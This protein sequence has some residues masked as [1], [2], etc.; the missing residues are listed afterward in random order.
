MSGES[1]GVTGVVLAGGN[2]R[3]FDAGDKALATLD[4]ET[5]LER[6]LGTLRASTAQPPIVAVQTEAQREQL[7]R[8]LPP[9]WDVRFVLDDS[10]LAGPL[11]GLLSACEA[12]STPWIFAVGCDMPLLDPRAVRELWTRVANHAER[13]PEAVVP[14]SRRGRR[15]PLHAFYRRSAVISHRNS[16]SDESSFNA[17]LAE[18]DHVDYAELNELP[19]LIRLSTT[20]INTVAELEH[21]TE[22]QRE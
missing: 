11:A 8:T 10:S 22:R 9:S 13:A 14:V 7:R 17:F 12:A 2:S 16:V 19:Q 3:R 20:N 21:V 1:P 18:F 6:V 15:E 5:F 4:G